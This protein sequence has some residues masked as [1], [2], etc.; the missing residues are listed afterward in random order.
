MSPYPIVTTTKKRQ[1]G[2]GRWEKGTS[3][4]PAGRPRGSKN[5]ASLFHQSLSGDEE[6]ALFQKTK[7][8]ALDGNLWALKFLMER[9]SPR[10]KDR[11]IQL[12][13]PNIQTE[14]D[15]AAAL[16][17][18][19][20]AVTTGE[21]T[22]AEGKALDDLVSR[23][24][25]GL[26]SR[27]QTP[28]PLH[29]NHDDE[30]MREVDSVEDVMPFDDDDDDGELSC[31]TGILDRRIATEEP[32]S[33]CV[34]RPFA[35]G[36][37]TQM[38][39][40]AVKSDQGQQISGAEHCLSTS[41]VRQEPVQDL[42]P[43]T[44]PGRAAPKPPGVAEAAEGDAAEESGGSRETPHQDLQL[45]RDPAF[46]AGEDRLNGRTA[47]AEPNLN[48]ENSAASATRSSREI[49]QARVDVEPK[50]LERT[51][52]AEATV[53]AEHD[54]EGGADPKRARPHPNPPPT[55]PRP[56]PMSE[57]LKRR[58]TPLGQLNGVQIY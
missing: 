18:I 49:V 54:L 40:P 48:S 9:I 15:I 46:E 17:K 44:E 23:R 52:A 35:V 27:S 12:S 58:M 56:D 42:I 33:G 28:V 26:H 2:T 14:R 39:P 21:I 50:P 6:E 8:L 3:G 53:S 22:P 4:N 5:K 25:R 34:S 10:P 11:L 20:K 1:P 13:L 41:E 51:E 57:E 16:K 31:P 45:K 30:G 36:T 19:F 32:K 38:A 43:P 55:P 29:R 37:E 7:A 24:R 47:T